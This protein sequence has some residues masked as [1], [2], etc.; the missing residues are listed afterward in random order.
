MIF[1]VETVGH[2]ETAPQLSRQRHKEEKHVQN[3]LWKTPTL[4]HHTQ[5]T[6]RDL[7][8][9]FKSE[10]NPKIDDKNQKLQKGK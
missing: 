5:Q 4:T 8:N 9:K 6:A 10:K 1:A 7:T 3:F 2:F